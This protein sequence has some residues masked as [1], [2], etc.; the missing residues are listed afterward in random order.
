MW[1]QIIGVPVITVLDLTN[2]RQWTGHDLSYIIFRQ[3]AQGT[4]SHQLSAMLVTLHAITL[5]GL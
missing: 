2:S 1:Y 3:K 4:T 5:K